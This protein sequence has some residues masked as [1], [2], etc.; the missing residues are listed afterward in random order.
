MTPVLSGLACLALPDM[1]SFPQDYSISKYC[2]ENHG[3]ISEYGR[4]SSSILL[5][6]HPPTPIIQQS[7][8]KPH[9][10]VCAA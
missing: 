10:V 9:V 1:C 2:V 4:C 3:V 5:C 7:A 6:S 8:M